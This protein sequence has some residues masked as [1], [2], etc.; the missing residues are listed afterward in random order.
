MEEFM[1]DDFLLESDTARVLYH[2]YGAKMPIL[3]FHNHLDAEAIWENRHFNN[4]A[5]V[6]LSQ[7][8]YK[9]RAMRAYGISEELITGKKSG[10]YE[11]FVAWAETVQNAFG[12]PLYH[13]THLELQR[14]F[15][16]QEILSPKTAEKI[17]KE[18]NEKLSGEGFS[19]RNILEMQKVEVLCTTDDPV[20]DLQAHKNLKESGFH[21]QVL[22]TFRPEKAIG[23][24]KE[25][26]PEYIR[27]L[28]E[29]TGKKIKSAE[30]VVEAL[31]IRLDYFVQCGCCVT[32]HS[33]EN[34]F[35]RDVSVDQ[36][37]EIFKKR[38]EGNRLTE[39]ECAKYHGYLLV[40][41]GKAYARKKLVMQIHI[42]AI[43]NNAGR[44][45]E[46]LGADCGVDSLNDFHYASE[47]SHLLDAMD[48]AD[49]L[50]KTILYYLNP[51]DAPMLAA[52]AGNFQG[53]EDGIKGKIQ[54]GTA[55]WFCDHKSGM[56]QQME[57][58]ASTG[59]LS[60]FIGMLT[61]SRSFLSFPRHEYFRRI[62]CNKIGGAVERKEY[63]KDMD[64][65]GKMVQNICYYNAKN[66]FGL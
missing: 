6:W 14:Y 66:Y 31:K 9:W 58:L 2:Q 18:C 12:N 39:E 48:Q 22:P 19:V 10:T 24:E 55:W 7:D 23:I 44:F 63:P 35:Y 36:V 21:I 5:Q 51:K 4:I 50:P 46:A 59:L 37:D 11:Q 52:M 45:Y 47:L 8:H 41:L 54:L 64:D 49:E 62:L 17:W 16:I 60:T 38:M 40:K 34:S 32:D 3:D 15:G 30:D 56:E 61:D 1:D 28:E 42:G 65:L 25:R 20:D 27:C 26:F 13:W 53:N 29:K 33:L 57:V 43:R